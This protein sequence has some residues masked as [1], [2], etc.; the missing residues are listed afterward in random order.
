VRGEIEAFLAQLQ[1]HHRRA[2]ESYAELAASG[3]VLLGIESEFRTALA[4]IRDASALCETDLPRGNGRRRDRQARG[5]VLIRETVALLERRLTDLRS[6]AIRGERRRTVDLDAEI[7]DALKLLEDRA[8]A[9]R[10]Q[11]AV[12]SP[13]AGRLARA[14]I[15]PENVRRM[16]LLLFDNS[17]WSLARQQDRRVQI[18]IWTRED[19]AGFDF[20]DNG[21]GIPA[22]RAENV[23]L[24]HYTTR[25]GA[26]GMGLTIVREICRSHG[27]DASVF[28]APAK[29]GVA[30]RI[31]LKRKQAR[32][33]TA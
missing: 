24:P 31:E 13:P 8:R 27:G 25:P 17:L 1:E 12:R 7:R 6:L 26:A 5:V 14:E 9:H 3:Q 32:A 20:W 18:R 2:L 16:L 4:A 29:G 10:V 22:D 15:R 19:R 30:V 11:L 21:P 23:F 33:T 28:P